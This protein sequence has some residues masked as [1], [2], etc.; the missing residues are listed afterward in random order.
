MR[1]IVIGEDINLVEKPPAQKGVSGGIIFHSQSEEVTIFHASNIISEGFRNFTIGHELGHYFLP[2]HPEEIISSSPIH[3]S[4]AGFSQGASSIEIEADHFSAGLLMPSRLVRKTLNEGQ[5]GLDDV[6]N[7]AERSKCSLTAS[8]IRTAE[9]AEYPM[10]IIV[11]HKDF[12]SYGFMSESFKSLKPTYPR[13]GDSLPYTGTREFNQ[14][15]DNVFK[16]KRYV[17]RANS[18]NGLGQRQMFF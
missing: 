9:C 18:L 1:A 7:L 13:K 15:V 8:A 16:S 17:T 2:G 3:L 5:V 14:D 12:I 4:R 11:S 6:L 10:A